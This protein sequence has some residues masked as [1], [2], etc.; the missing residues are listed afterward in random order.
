MH[1]KQ[2][3]QELPDKNKSRTIKNSTKTEWRTTHQF[4]S[5]N[6]LKILDSDATATYQWQI[7]HWANAAK[8][9]ELQ[10]NI[11]TH[12]QWN[13][14]HYNVQ[15]RLDC[16]CQTTCK[17]IGK[18]HRNCHL[19]MAKHSAKVLNCCTN[20]KHRYCIKSAE[21]SKEIVI[22]TELSPTCHITQ[23]CTDKSSRQ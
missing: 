1:L 2:N 13:S 7:K 19:K 15:H 21:Q 9:S 4:I 18:V 16:K 12:M 3:T 17:T 11:R 14:K 23:D 8:S 5:I 22:C 20:L 6:P 10:I